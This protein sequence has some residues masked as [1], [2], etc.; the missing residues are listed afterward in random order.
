[1]LKVDA[2]ELPT[3]EPAPRDSLRV[4]QWTLAV[5]KAID[6]ATPNAS[7]GVLSALD[8]IWGKAIQTD[9]KVSPYNYGGPLIDLQGRVIGVLVPLS[10]TN[11]SVMA[12]AEWYDSGIGFAIPMDQ[13]SA[14]VERLKAG[15]DLFRGSLGVTPKNAANLFAHPILE[16]V[17]QAE[18][19]KSEFRSGDQITKVEDVAVKTIS[20]VMRQLGPRYAGE[21]IRVTVS[22][23][24]TETEL[25][26]I[27]KKPEKT[28]ILP[29]RE[30]TPQPGDQGEP[31]HPLPNPSIPSS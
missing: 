20:D 26:V 8:R 1:V 14:S 29:P 19:G 7:P 27:L 12:G 4:G 9:S 31:E 22:R 23:D 2:A 3:S 28:S 5:G 15:E 30:A 13:V 18:E 6:P 10:M 17:P 16:N 21:E 11:D 24:G 25:T